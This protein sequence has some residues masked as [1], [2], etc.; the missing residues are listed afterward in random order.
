MVTGDTAQSWV[1]LD[2]PTRLDFEYM[3]RI[4]EVLQHTVLL[5]P[6]DQRIRAVHLGGGGFSLPRYLAAVRPHTAQ[7][8]CEPDVE[9]LAEVRR[10]L[11]LPPRSGIKVREVDGRS[12]LAAMPADYADVVIL[13]AFDGFQIPGL[14][15]TAEA[16]TEMGRVLTE[17]GVMIAN[18]ADQAPFTWLKRC[19]A[20][21]A[22]VWPHLLVSAEPAVFRGRRFG[23]LVVVGSLGRLPAKTLGRVWSG[24]P[25]PYRLMAGAELSRWLESARPFSDTQ[26]ISSPGPGRRRTW[27]G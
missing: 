14:L 17:D 11:P 20:G 21:M 18:L 26:P 9:L 8:V 16:F 24:V 10:V 6:S 25:F 27:F 5:R 1:D 12:G 19:L 13:D 7:I 3:Q 2:D 23:N 4:A 15:A 22:A